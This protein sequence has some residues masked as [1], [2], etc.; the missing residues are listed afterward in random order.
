M[1]GLAAILVT[2]LGLAVGVPASAQ[3]DAQTLKVNNLQQAMTLMDAWAD[4][5][6]DISPE[7]SPEAWAAAWAGSRPALPPS[8][9]VGE[10]AVQWAASHPETRSWLSKAQSSGAPA[11]IEPTDALAW[12]L[13]Q[14]GQPQVSPSALPAF[15]VLV[16]PKIASKMAKKLGIAAGAVATWLLSE[17]ACVTWEGFG[18]KFE[19]CASASD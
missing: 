2:A 18:V 7:Q 14:P 6:S 8:A 1:K 4:A 13:G 5:R 9:D 16:V 3:G 19:M 17:Q 10:W 15:A 11:R 12:A